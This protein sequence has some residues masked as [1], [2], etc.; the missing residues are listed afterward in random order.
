MTGHPT[1]LCSPSR[2]AWLTLLLLLAA[3]CGGAS[4]TAIG[5]SNGSER[6]RDPSAGPTPN[7]SGA[8]ARATPT[9]SDPIPIYEDG[10]RS[11]E[12]C[13]DQAAAEGL[14]VIDF[15]DDWTPLVFTDVPEL[16]GA[17]AQPYRSTYLA[18]ASEHRGGKYLELYGIFPTFEV[19]RGRMLDDQAHECHAQVSHEALSSLEHAI[20]GGGRTKQR[21]AAAQIRAMRNRLQEAAQARGVASVRD[22][23]SDPR[24][25]EDV[26]RYERERVD[27]ESVEALQQHLR[28]ERLLAANAR[29]DE[30]V[31][32]NA[33]AWALRQWQQKHM[34]VYGGRLDRTT[35][36]LLLLESRERDFR[37][38]LR[39]LRE[40]VIS[41]TG[42]IEDGTA[43]QQFGTVLGR[44]IDG[45]EFRAPAG[46]R[47]HPDGAP[48]LISPATEAAASALGWTD[49]DKVVEFFRGPGADTGHLKLAVRLPPLPAYHS[50]HMD[51]R[52][53]VD[54]GDVWYQYPFT[55][56]GGVR[57][58]PVRVR[59]VMT[60][61]VR[62]EG[63]EI[64][65]MRFGTTIGGWKE[66]AGPDGKLGYTYKNSPVGARIWRDVIASPAWLPPPNTP[67]SDL[68][69][70]EGGRNAPNLGLTGPGYRSAYGLAMM[71][72]T[73][74]VT[75]RDGNQRFLD[76]GIRAHGSVSYPSILRGTSHGCHRLF[77]HLAVRLAS[78][79]VGHRNHV[80]H[81]SMQIDFHHA[82]SWEGQRH[83]IEIDSRGYHFEL[84]PP[85][86]V[87]VLEGRIRGGVDEP[88]QGYRP[89][90][91]DLQNAATTARASGQTVVEEPTE[92]EEEA[93][94]D[95]PYLEG[96]PEVD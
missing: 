59:P 82:F 18:L 71:M 14:T 57:G 56:T 70:R 47:P 93:D 87:E 29:Y 94:G 4:T 49:P 23:A 20:G 9:C 36:E 67:P 37:S 64:A 3:A 31:F 6:G 26:E 32:D 88:L 76:E 54:R 1:S 55:S 84:T 74:V 51:L 42:L 58:Q 16:S 78:F 22:L 30:G 92:P 38:V 28:C 95:H 73:R 83:E 40:R 41:A 61:F 19:L 72:H 48:D 45:D 50:A 65:L 63:R 62:H 96:Q 89:L 34:V 2:R 24:H 46:H 25:R 52:A 17:S 75:D 43:S 5:S 7:G 85:V 13:P 8:T 35:R 90:R 12:V 21:R 66:E 11:G 60:L 15:S 44:H 91:V 39:V 53:E 86:P 77:N 80:R 81:G 27:V 69:H 79:L 33:T 68:I 10:R